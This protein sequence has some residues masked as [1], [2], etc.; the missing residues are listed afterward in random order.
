MTQTLKD[1]K[2]GVCG[3]SEVVK[4]QET[5]LLEKRIRQIKR[6]L[7]VVRV[8]GLAERTGKS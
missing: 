8:I 3:D 7:F 1:D 4:N 5:A 6:E 2:Q